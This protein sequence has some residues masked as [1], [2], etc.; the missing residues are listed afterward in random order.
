MNMNVGRC[1][2]WARTSLNMGPVIWSLLGTVAVSHARS[3][4]RSDDPGCRC[5]AG[6]GILLTEY[7]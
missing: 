1:R 4:D 3:R 5:L 6:I 2:E 7:Q